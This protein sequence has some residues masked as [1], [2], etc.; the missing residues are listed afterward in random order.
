MEYLSDWGVTR[1]PHVHVSEFGS[2]TGSPSSS[3]EELPQ[4]EEKDNSAREIRIH[5]TERGLP[6]T[7]PND[8][9]REFW[10]R[11]QHRSGIRLRIFEDSIVYRQAT[12]G[13]LVQVGEDI[14]GLTV[15]HV[16]SKEYS[17][18]RSDAGEQPQQIPETAPN[19]DSKARMGD[20]STLS[21]RWRNPFSQN[22]VFDWAL[23]EIPSIETY[24]PRPEEWE[25]VNLVETTSG[26]FRPVL[27]VPGDKVEVERVSP[28][29]IKVRNTNLAVPEM[30]INGTPVVLATPG[31]TLCLRGILTGEDALVNMP[32][33]HSPYVT[34]VLRMEQPWLIRPGD[35]G[36][37]AFD[38][39]TGDLLGILVAGCPELHEVYIIPA[40][41]VFRD[42]SRTLGKDVRLPNC[43]NITEQD[44]QE[45]TRL[46][47]T[48][49]GLR[50][51]L[52]LKRHGT[53]VFDLERIDKDATLCFSR[54]RALFSNSQQGSLNNRRIYSRWVSP[55]DLQR[56]LSRAMKAYEDDSQGFRRVLES[57]SP[58]DKQLC[59]DILRRSPLECFNFVLNNL[60]DNLLKDRDITVPALLWVHLILGERSLML[61]ESDVST[62]GYH[63]SQVIED[64]LRSCASHSMV[65]HPRDRVSMRA[66]FLGIQNE[67][68]DFISSQK[69][70]YEAI[71]PEMAP[72]GEF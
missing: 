57:L 33:S 20:N 71:I 69:G 45:L 36:S 17:A 43:Y 18:Q 37:W 34:W 50:A 59:E 51:E 49:L 13:G 40:Y 60:Q 16:F 54:A 67:L 9:T 7:V 58:D 27:V 11:R 53:S 41:Q 8:T 25:D 14:F 15:A 48:I 63:I 5:L 21:G 44:H 66:G 4:H 72:F 6:F 12:I 39:G 22:M 38:T 47:K 62:G 42:I 19:Q 3:S 56:H 26:D 32:G 52:E 61:S 64:E 70:Y 1:L 68:E 46:E 29:G 55:H 30:P 35:S 28:K 10:H 2:P 31:A 23:V 24:N 65:T